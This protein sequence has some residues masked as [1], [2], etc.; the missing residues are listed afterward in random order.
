MATNE[1]QS[2]LAI[3]DLGPFGF[4]KHGLNQ[5]VKESVKFGQNIWDFSLLSFFSV[6]SSN[7]RISGLKVEAAKLF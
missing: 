1:A 5:K 2:L 7:W 6:F 3:L 4:P